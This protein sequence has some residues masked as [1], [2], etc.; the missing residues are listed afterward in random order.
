MLS[1]CK[2]KVCSGQTAGSEAASAMR[3]LFENEEF[4]AV[5]LVDDAANAFNDINR[6]ALLHNIKI[7]CSTGCPRKLVT[8]LTCYYYVIFI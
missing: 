4:E 2:V 6:N 8:L 7:Q 3:K 5:L 1:C